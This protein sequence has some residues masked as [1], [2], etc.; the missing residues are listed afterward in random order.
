MEERNILAF[1][2]TL[3]EAEKCQQKLRDRGFDVVQI[4][5]VAADMGT[6]VPSHSPLVD[7]GRYGYDVGRLDDKW[8]ASGAWLEHGLSVGVWILTAVVPPE[9][10]D[11]ASTIIQ[12]SGGQF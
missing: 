8:T 5:S 11:D 10:Q 1:F 9:D 2:R 7:W 6:Q 4:D 3:E 12:A